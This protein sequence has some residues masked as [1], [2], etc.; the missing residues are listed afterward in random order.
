M[1]T[2]QIS[3]RVLLAMVLLVLVPWA[4]GQ[5]QGG[6]KGGGAGSGGAGSGGATGSPSRGSTPSQPPVLSQPG[7]RQGQ[8]QEI[9]REIFFFGMVVQ[10]DGAPLPMGTEIER[11]CN[12]RAKREATVDSTGH[13]S[14]QVGGL[15]NFSNVLPEAS[16]DSF[17]NQGVFGDGNP[18]Q[19]GTPTEMTGMTG[20]TG[21]NSASLPNLAGCEVRARLSGYRSSSVMLQGVY[22]MGQVDLGTIVLY[23]VSKVPGT[24]V[25][26]TDMQAPKAAQKALDRAQ[27]DIRKKNLAEAE[28]N[29][30]AAIAAYPKYAAAWFTLGKVYQQQKRIEDAR[31][32]YSTAVAADSRYVSPYIQLAQLAGMER[33]WQEVADITD[34]AL[35]LDP[36]DF[37]EGYLFNSMAYYNLKK[38]DAAERSALKVQRLDGTNRFPES[39]LILAN[40]LPQTQDY[41]GTMAQLRL[42]LKVAPTASNAAQV[43]TWLQELEKSPKA[44]ADK[45]PAQPNP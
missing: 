32:A 25:S 37:P 13:F 33:K 6:S 2:G 21:M 4:F 17:G 30:N 19:S 16:D 9:Q 41:P 40:I 5:Q 36:V 35:A 11:V 38:L 45:Q 3:P 27:K 39:H 44:M 22:S 20:M 12:A 7:T 23:P 34:R 15:N 18:R 10:E 26:I 43:Q 14:F 31:K 42:Y 29:L 8:Q 24:L 28:K 1:R